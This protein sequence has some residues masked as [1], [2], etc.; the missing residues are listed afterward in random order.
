MK[1]YIIANNLLYFTPRLSMKKIINTT[2]L[3][4]IPLAII[5][6]SND[7]DVI[8]KNSETISVQNAAPYV[9]KPKTELY[10]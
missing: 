4:I 10:I 7:D 2:L 8:E 5:S 6:C 1:L 3:L 9:E